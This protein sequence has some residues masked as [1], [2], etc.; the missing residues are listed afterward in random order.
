LRITRA[1][2]E[3]YTE[4]ANEKIYVTSP[5]KG[6]LPNWDW[7]LEKFKEQ[8]FC[9]GVDIFVIDAFNKV[10]MPSGNRLDNINDVLTKL[11]AFAQANDVI[12][13]LVAH[14]TKMKKNESGIYDVPTLYDV[15]GSAD[16]RNQTHDGF[17]VYRK[18]ENPE[19]GEEGCT[20]VFNMKTKYKFQGEIGKSARMKYHVPTGRY[21][22]DGCNPPLFDMTIPIEQQTLV[23]IISAMKPNESFL[24]ID[25]IDDEEDPTEISP[26]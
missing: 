26:F 17:S 11:T 22:D 7:I 3:R 8:L 20:E 24:S 2:I 5:E 18:F 6:E 4:W 12:I 15:S 9:Y 14:P 25:D 1:D 16:F 19:T 23:P 13:F 10:A 21:Y